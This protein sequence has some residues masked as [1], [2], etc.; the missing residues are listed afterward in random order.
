[1]GRNRPIQNLHSGP[2]LS[3][4]YSSPAG[5]PASSFPLDYQKTAPRQR[6]R[7]WAC[8]F[9]LTSPDILV[10]NTART[11]DRSTV[12]LGDN[13]FCPIYGDGTL[14]CAQL[15]KDGF[16]GRLLRH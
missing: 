15:R 16:E 1:M 2:S 9:P 8:R 5:Q 4:H 3:R 7:I 6:A 13:L 12:P 14:D 11:A 10:L